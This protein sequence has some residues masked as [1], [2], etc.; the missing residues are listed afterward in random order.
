[1]SEC[2]DKA[3]INNGIKASTLLVGKACILSVGFG[4]GQVD[5]GVGNIQVA[6]E[7]DR[8]LDFKLFDVSEEINI[9]LERAVVEAAGALV[10]V[11]VLRVGCVNGDEI[12]VIEFC[13]NDASLLVVLFDSKAVACR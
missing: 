9:P 8:L 1:M 2:V 12:V 7:Y 13:R 10:L 4:I 11:M 6:A 5:F 3:C